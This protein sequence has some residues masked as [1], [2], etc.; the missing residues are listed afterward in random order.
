MITVADLNPVLIAHLSALDACNMP[1]RGLDEIFST[2]C[3]NGDTSFPGSGR[4][5]R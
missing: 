4:T 5:V 1:L 2:P 3:V